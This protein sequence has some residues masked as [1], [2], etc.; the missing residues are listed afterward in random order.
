MKK[1]IALGGSN[2]K[3]SI[4]KVLATYAAHEVK[5]AIVDVVDLNDYP[6]PL[7]GT[8]LEAENGI[9][10]NAI[11]LNNY[12]DQADGLV[13]SLAEHNGSYAAFFKNTM[14]WLSRIDIKVWKDKPMLLLATSPGAR[15]GRTV[16]EQAKVSFPHLGGNII[17]DFSLVKFYENFSEN[18][19]TDNELREE[20]NLKI[21]FF[22]QQL[23][24]A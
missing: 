6:L 4:N 20:L 19:I 24:N 5:N 9:P 12:L 3:K 14:D 7:Y 21:A 13:I 8:D 11:N 15:G 18:R 1:I 16:L 22:E 2:S 23:N 10:E 17:T